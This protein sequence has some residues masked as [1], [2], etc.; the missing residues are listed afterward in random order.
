MYTQPFVILR[1][2]LLLY[3]RYGA[4]SFGSEKYQRLVSLSLA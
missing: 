4:Y 1:W 3:S 2:V